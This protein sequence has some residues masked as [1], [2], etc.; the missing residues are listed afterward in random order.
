MTK[1]GC[2]SCAHIL[3]FL[4]CTMTWT[5]KVSYYTYNTNYS[6]VLQVFLTPNT[7]R[8]VPHTKLNADYTFTAG[9]T[10]QARGWMHTNWGWG[11]DQR[12]MM[13]VM[14]RMTKERPACNDND[15]DNE[16]GG[17]AS[18]WRGHQR[19]TR[20]PAHDKD[21]SAPSEQWERGP[22]HNEGDEGEASTQQQLDEQGWEWGWMKE[23]KSSVAMFLSRFLYRGK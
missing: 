21:T 7:E 10:R 4:T 17:D 12:T 2:V 15:Q 5:P 19:I 16:D 23:G 1:Y 11:W 9:T 6:F 18:A 14:T 22:T 8:W 20:M 3:C 13:M